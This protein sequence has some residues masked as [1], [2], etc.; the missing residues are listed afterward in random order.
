MKSKNKIIMLKYFVNVH[1]LQHMSL[2]I[3]VYQYLKKELLRTFSI[4][5]Y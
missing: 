1:R 5:Y 2:F 3:K 4:A